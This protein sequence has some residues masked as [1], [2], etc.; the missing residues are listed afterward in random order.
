MNRKMTSHRGVLCC[1]LV[2]LLGCKTAPPAAEAPPFIPFELLDA[3]EAPR[4]PLRYAIAAGTTTTSTLSW[5]TAPSNEA[6]PGT[7]LSGL[8]SMDMRIVR[9]PAKVVDNAVQYTFEVVDSTAKAGPGA[10]AKLR[11]EID[12]HKDY[13]TGTGRDVVLDDRGHH[14]GMRYN[15]KASNI[16]LRLLWTID[17]AFSLLS[18]VVL[19][20]EEVGVGARWTRRSM[21]AL[22]DIKMVQAAT[23]T[24]VERNGDEIVLDLEVERVG[25]R[26][27][28]E[29]AEDESLVE[30]ASSRMNVKGRIRLD[31]EALG[32][33]STA[34]G[35]A[36]NEVVFVEKGE[37]EARVIDE[38]F[39]IR[40]A[41]T[42]TVEPARR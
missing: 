22:Y 4:A 18:M 23:Y 40:I 3:G 6:R 26:Q 32:G 38:E 2:F 13:L 36:R 12:K 8:A 10:S 17:T 19:P 7:T 33:S 1:A 9:G 28:V 20:N 29:F 15:E 14:L 21:L 41:S 39:E 16:P 31:L 5:K 24:L 11:D 37:R 42:S 34:T 30:V 35:T 25:E 27:V